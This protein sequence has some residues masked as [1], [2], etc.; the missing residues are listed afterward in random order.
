MPVNVNLFVIFNAYS[1]KSAGFTNIHT[2]DEPT[3]AAT[4]YVIENKSDYDK[5]VREEGT[6]DDNVKSSSFTALVA[7]FGGGTSDFSK[8]D[9]NG[10][11]TA[12]EDKVKY[13]LA[14]RNI[15]G[16][17]Q[18]GGQDASKSMQIVSLD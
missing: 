4:C 10:S 3:A 2:A 5:K 1:A 13:E 14:G 12:G 6:E 15:T 11:I 16:L 18:F 7:D 8:I 17:Q 9:I